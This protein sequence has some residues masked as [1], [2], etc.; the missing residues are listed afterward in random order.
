MEIFMEIFLFFFYKSSECNTIILYTPVSPFRSSIGS[1][2][3]SSLSI[4]L[5]DWLTKLKISFTI[6]ATEI[7][8]FFRMILLQI[9][10][11]YFPKIM[12]DAQNMDILQESE[13]YICTQQLIA[14][15]FKYTQQLIAQWYVLLLIY[16]QKRKIMDF[17]FLLPVC[18][19]FF[20]LHG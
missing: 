12:N 19:I 4:S 8:F 9:Y 14:H 18:D 11:S 17:N 16:L 15:M 2:L 10:N 1:L 13:M 6:A 5:S 7:L 20:I 3:G